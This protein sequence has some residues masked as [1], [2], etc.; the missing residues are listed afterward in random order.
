MG[1]WGY[2]FS[3][4]RTARYTNQNGCYRP[5]S[6]PTQG[7]SMPK[8]FGPSNPST[9]NPRS[10]SLSYCMMSWQG[11]MYTSSSLPAPW[12]SSSR[13]LEPGLVLYQRVSNSNSSKGPKGHGSNILIPESI[14]VSVN[15]KA[16]EI[17]TPHF[18]PFIVA[19]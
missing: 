13:K 4:P 12:M 14:W 6:P 2:H 18:Y 3:Q 1:T 10:G 9:V 17:Y 8:T 19:I 15:C 11:V 7:S 5:A 16:W